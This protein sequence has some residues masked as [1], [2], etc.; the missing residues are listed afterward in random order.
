MRLGFGCSPTRVVTGHLQGQILDLGRG[1]GATGFAG[2]AAI[3]LVG[4][5]PPVPSKQSVWRNQRGDLEELFSADC[6]GLG[7][8]ATALTIGEQQALSA[9]L[10]AEHAVYSE[11]S[12]P[13]P[14]STR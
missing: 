6:L 12:L 13:P 10:L 4:D 1:L 14:A 3:V 8:E 11:A 2:L 7:C 5:Q 9:Q